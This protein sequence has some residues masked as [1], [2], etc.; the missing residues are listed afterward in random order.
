MKIL[1]LLKLDV[2]NKYIVNILTLE[3]ISY[4]LLNIKIMQ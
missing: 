4:F 1:L 2:Q 3:Q